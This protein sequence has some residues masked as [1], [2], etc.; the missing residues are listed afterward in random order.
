MRKLLKAVLPKPVIGLLAS[1]A[2]RPA[3]SYSSNGEDLVALALLKN[4]TSGF[5]VDVGCFHPKHSSNTYRLHRMGW[6]GLNIDADAYKVAVFNQ[7]RPSDMNVCAVISDTEG[8]AEFYSQKGGSYGSMSGLDKEEAYRRAEAL[9]REVVTRTVRTV[10]LS[11]IL[12]ERGV[13]KIDFLTIDVEGFEGAVLATLDF[14]RVEVDVVAVEIHG[15]LAAL[16]QSAA[17]RLLESHGFEIVAWTPPTVFY[18]RP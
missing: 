3:R 6:R 7:A 13:R 12:D 1:A 14:E 11:A 5:Y 18:R 8:E 16:R 17:A 10:P 2:Y 15:D 9:G 4:R